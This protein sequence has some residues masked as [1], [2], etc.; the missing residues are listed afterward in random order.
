MRLA[1]ADADQM[2]DVWE[3]GERLFEEG[4]V[5]ALRI[6][7]GKRNDFQRL[8]RPLL[9][10]SGDVDAARVLLEGLRLRLGSESA[11]SSE[12]DDDVGVFERDPYTWLGDV[13]DESLLPMLGECLALAYSTRRADPFGPF[14]QLN[15]AI[16]R[17]GGQK[18]IDVYDGLI[19]DK[20][21]AG[22]SFLRHNRDLI[23][24]D[25]LRRAGNEAAP[26]AFALL[27]L[28]RSKGQSVK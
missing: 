22:A 19:E 17:V 10:R 21:I 12:S 25:E 5:S 24:D 2:Y 6:L 16:R 27:G 20:S 13:R 26:S 11:A 3:V 7:A 18:A 15:A 1:S 9:A 28:S 14:S 23:L 8:L 4:R